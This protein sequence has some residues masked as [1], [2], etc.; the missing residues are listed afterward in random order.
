MRLVSQTP[1]V[2]IAV[3][4]RGTIDWNVVTRL[5]AIRDATPGLPPIH[6]QAGRLAVTDVRNRIVQWFLTDTTA[7][8]LLMVDDD[9]IPP[10]DVLTLA[11]QTKDVIGCPYF[12]AR[13]PGLQI[14]VPCVLK[15]VPDGPS[16]R[17]ETFD[18][19]F[20]LSGL[21][22]VG[23]MGTGCLM[24]HRRVLTH[25]SLTIPFRMGHDAYGRMTITE[26]ILFCKR[27]TDVGFH[28]WADMDRMADHF[29]SGLSLNDL[30]N[31]F[32]AAFEHVKGQERPVK[33]LA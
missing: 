26:D 21:L 16:F 31:G 15:R 13:P 14:P 23:A 3:P 12:I 11:D 6:Y 27:A 29:I 25:P 9:V 20:G 32:V 10:M 30:M 28:I 5:N 24:I 2:V 1:S 17:F 8:Y 22:E 7:P 19:P 4:T 33:E 18:Q